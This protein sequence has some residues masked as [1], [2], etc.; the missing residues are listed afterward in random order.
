MEAIGR[1]PTRAWNQG[2][3]TVDLRQIRA[4][5]ADIRA[6]FASTFAWIRTVNANVIRLY[7][8]WSVLETVR[9][10]CFQLSFRNSGSV[11]SK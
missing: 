5:F 7:P 4:G 11:F 3:F 9:N 2:S 1:V 10:G 8:V 6:G